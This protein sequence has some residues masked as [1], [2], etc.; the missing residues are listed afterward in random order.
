MK[1]A[2]PTKLRHLNA[3]GSATEIQIVNDPN[4]AGICHV[5]LR[6]FDTSGAEAK[7]ALVQLK[8]ESNGNVEV[9]VNVGMALPVV[10]ENGS[11]VYP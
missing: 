5:E 6:N 7:S 4:V 10:I 1:I 9:L 2:N 8:C 3:D 11:Q